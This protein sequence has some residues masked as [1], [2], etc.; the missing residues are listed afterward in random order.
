MAKTIKGWLDF[1]ESYRP[2]DESEALN[3]RQLVDFLRSSDNPFDR[4]NLLAHCVADALIVNPVRSHALML[5]HGVSGNWMS[6]GGH[7]DGDADLC[8][9][10]L[11]EAEEETGLSQAILM[12]LRGGRLWDV[13]VGLVPERISRYGR[14]PSHLHFDICFAFEAEDSFPLKISDESDDLAWLPVQ[15]A[16]DRTIPPHRRRFA[17]LQAGWEDVA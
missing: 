7:A 3:C 16:C 11:R 12:P 15:D 4:S 5:V 14:E 6:P 9:G 10:A 8:A 13:N 1:L 17:K 2:F